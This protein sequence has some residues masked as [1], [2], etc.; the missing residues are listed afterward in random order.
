MIICSS[1]KSLELDCNKRGIPHLNGTCECFQPFGGDK[2]EKFV[3]PL[4]CDSIGNDLF[5]LNVPSYNFLS[6]S[7]SE[8]ECITLQVITNSI[9]RGDV[10][11]CFRTIGGTNV[12][13]YNVSTTESTD[14]AVKY[15]NK[16]Y[17]GCNTEI[18][19]G[20]EDNSTNIF[21]V[22]ENS[23]TSIDFTFDECLEMA[24]ML[25]IS[26]S[27]FKYPCDFFPC[28]HDKPCE[29]LNIVDFKCDCGKSWRGNTCDEKNVCSFK[30]TKSYCKNGGVCSYLDNLPKCQCQKGWMG[31]RCNVKNYCDQNIPYCLNGGKCK[32]VKGR[33]M[34]DCDNGYYGEKCVC[35]KSDMTTQ[36]I[37]LSRTDCPKK[38][39]PQ[40]YKETKNG[41]NN[42]CRCVKK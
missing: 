25:D 30:S 10:F 41:C 13:Y 36:A 4:M 39:K 14:N 12:L 5:V 31:T 20:D 19:S 15:L 9:V 3:S 26:N 37:C 27:N 21:F 11:A 32:Y 22:N 42:E 29:N 38:T 7:L 6:L 8:K 23:I 18:G 33:P 2:C 24:S 28:K 40:F 1:V 35:K 34:C 16:F 17:S